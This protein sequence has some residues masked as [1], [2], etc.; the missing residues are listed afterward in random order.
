MKLAN[1]LMER[2]ITMDLEARTK[3]QAVRELLDMLKR[4]GIRLDYDAVL[5]SIGERE[6]IENTSYGRGF[7][8]PHARTDAVEE[9]YILIGLSRQ[10]LEDKTP[11]DVPVHMV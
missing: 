2:R 10:G 6:E 4:E 3:E 8:F 9:M 1:L 7:A 5:E 11:D